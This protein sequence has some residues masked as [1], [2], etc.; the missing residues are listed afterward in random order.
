MQ[1][2]IFV[3]LHHPNNCFENIYI[4]Y[5]P[6]FNSVAKKLFLANKKYWGACPLLHLQC[7]WLNLC[8]RQPLM[9]VLLNCPLLLYENLQKLAVCK[10]SSSSSC[11]SA[12]IMASAF[13]LH[14]ILSVNYYCCMA[15]PVQYESSKSMLLH[16]GT[17]EGC[18]LV[19]HTSVS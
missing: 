11:G 15:I 8:L 2:F 16:A 7:L 3:S 13:T 9:K 1:V 14:N 4:F 6:L 12:K 10:D 5:L 18:V 19:C 17:L